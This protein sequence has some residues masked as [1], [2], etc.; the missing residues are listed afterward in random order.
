VASHESRPAAVGAEIVGVGW[1]A[2]LVGVGVGVVGGAKSFA[3]FCA[4]C[5]YIRSGG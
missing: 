2:E 1:I 5:C 4:A 3:I